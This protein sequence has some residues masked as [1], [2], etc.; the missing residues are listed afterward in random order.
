MSRI[1]ALVVFL[2]T[3]CVPAR[4]LV[5]SNARILD[6]TG[7][8]IEQGSIVVSDGRI[9]SVSAGDPEAE[10]VLEIDAQGMTVMPGLIDT[11]VHVLS[12]GWA[13]ES[14]EELEEYM[15][16]SDIPADL[17]SPLEWSFD[18]PQPDWGAVAPWNPE[19]ESAT[20]TRT[21][22][23]IRI[24]LGEDTGNLDGLP[25]GGLVVE[26]P[27]LRVGDWSA[28]EVRA[29]TSDPVQRIGAGFNL[30]E[31]SGTASDQPYPFEFGVSEP[32]IPDGE[33]HVYRLRTDLAAREQ[34]RDGV[35]R[36]L[37]LWI[38]SA[39]PASID[40]L[41]VRLVPAEPQLPRRLRSILEAGFT[42]VMSPGD[43]YP[44]IV[45]VRRR[46]D[47][48]ELQGPRLL[49][50]GLMFLP[51][52][53]TGACSLTETWCRA[54]IYFAAADPE[55]ARAMVRE[56][57]NSGADAIK[58]GSSVN[59]D[60]LAAIAA[61][62][63]R[64]DLPLIVHSFAAERTLKA[65]ELGANRFVHLAGWNSRVNQIITEAGIPVSTTVWRRSY[66]P[67][68]QAA[69]DNVGPLWDEGVTIAFGTDRGG[70]PPTENLLLEARAMAQTLSTEQIITSLTRNAAAYLDLSGEI[71][72]LEP[73]KLADIVIID[74]DPLADLSD[75]A[76]VVLVIKGGEVVVDNR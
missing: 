40:I 68:F 72:T 71:G 45:E 74:G 2:V 73:G 8:V 65:I 51:V 70:V 14:D 9:V 67:E 17:P 75:L 76:K 60:V 21:T 44:A 46:L 35:W 43:F 64:L 69:V 58:A 55:A 22:D 20:V 66:T 15:N 6:G 16:G 10:G 23:A 59:D 31:G 62:A 36:E 50:V 28:V 63:R 38:A 42:T 33:A 52:G 54:G 34:G 56:L 37:G 41:S 13:L 53:A 3:S 48:G 24:T 30:R 61:E 11:H 32:V 49:V 19:I 47:S 5:I 25:R 12:G 26:V 29:R 7:G 18:R 1:A 27:S 4:D 39:E 57:A